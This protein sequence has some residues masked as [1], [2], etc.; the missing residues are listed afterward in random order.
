MNSAELA[1]SALPTGLADVADERAAWRLTANQRTLASGELDARGAV[2]KPADVT[3]PLRWPKVKEGA[4]LA[5]QLT[6]SVGEVRHERAVWVFPRDPFA[7]RREWLKELKLTVF[8]PPG[9]TVEVFKDNNIPHGRI[10]SRDALDNVT[11]GIVVIGEGGRR[12]PAGRRRFFRV[13]WQVREPRVG[14]SSSGGQSARPPQRTGVGSRSS[15]D[16]RARPDRTS[17][18]QGRVARGRWGADDQ[19]NQL[20]KPAW[21][22][23]PG[24]KPGYE[25]NFVAERGDEVWF[26]GHQWDY[27]NSSG[28]YRINLK[29]GAFHKFGP[30]DGFKTV[31][32]HSLFDGIWLRDRLWLGTSNGLCVVTPR[33]GSPPKT[34]GEPEK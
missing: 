18:R 2:D 16:R 30:A 25:V 28:L 11:E 12:H 1:T 19:T 9:E 4:V 22:F 3:I 29:T 33:N 13:R 5:A 20:F 10:R 21:Y 8:D 32:A 23:V 6:V 26:G 17:R 7:D 24:T 27:F 34:P 31:H 14:E 15:S